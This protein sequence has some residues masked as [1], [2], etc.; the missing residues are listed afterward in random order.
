MITFEHMKTADILDFG[1]PHAVY[2]GQFYVP[3]DPE[4]A[5]NYT[6]EVLFVG[7]M[8]QV[9]SEYQRADSIYGLI[10]AFIQNNYNNARD[11]VIYEYVNYPNN[12]VLDNA[13]YGYK[14]RYV[15]DKNELGFLDKFELKP[16]TK[17][18]DILDF[19]E[20]MRVKVGEVYQHNN[21]Q[22]KSHNKLV[23]GVGTYRNIHTKYPNAQPNLQ[24]YNY[25][26][27][28]DDPVIVYRYFDTDTNDW[29]SVLSLISIELFLE[30]NTLL[31][32]ER[33]AAYPQ[34]TGEY[35]FDDFKMIATKGQ[36]WQ[37]ASTTIRIDKIITPK[38]LRPLS[39]FFKF[40]G[41]WT[42]IGPQAIKALLPSSKT[43]KFTTSTAP[44]TVSR[45][46]QP[47]LLLKT[48]V[49]EY[50]ITPKEENTAVI[51][52]NSQQTTFN[53]PIEMRLEQPENGDNKL[54]SMDSIPHEEKVANILEFGDILDFNTPQEGEYY[55]DKKH[56]LICKVI[57]VGRY[58]E[59]DPYKWFVYY[60]FTQFANSSSFIQRLDT[61]ITEFEK[62]YP[63]QDKTASILNFGDILDSFFPNVGEFYYHKETK[64]VCEVLAVGSKAHVEEVSGWK[65]SPEM[66]LIWYGFTSSDWYAGHVVPLS[67]FMEN[68]IKGTPPQKTAD[69]LEFD[70]PEPTP[71]I[72]R[73]Y[74][75][76]ANPLDVIK[77]VAFGKYNDLVKTFPRVK[78]LT[79]GTV[80][81]D[82]RRYFD[83]SSGI[84][85]FEERGKLGWTPLHSKTMTYSFDKYVPVQN[86]TSAMKFSDILEHMDF[87]SDGI[88]ATQKLINVLK[89]HVGRE[90]NTDIA[91][92]I[93]VYNYTIPDNAREHLS[94]QTIDDLFWDTAQWYLEDFIGNTKSDYSWI[95]EITQAGRSGGWLEITPNGE[96]LLYS[97]MEL[98]DHNRDATNAE[99]MWK[100][101]AEY[102]I[103]YTEGPDFDFNNPEFADIKR[104]LA[105]E[106]DILAT[107][108]EIIG[109]SVQQLVRGFEK[110]MSDPN[111]WQE[112]IDQHNTEASNRSS[113]MT[114]EAH[115]PELML[116]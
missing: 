97:F 68:F 79:T 82:A 13:L 3:T 32:N 52:D 19:D 26:F 16:Y 6:V 115:L 100:Y 31:P 110:D 27:K 106:I 80:L 25:D 86:T 24:E 35:T 74:C 84:V 37:T 36:V 69:I 64:N 114:K 94:E 85:I 116:E 46:Y 17:Q 102:R 103:E 20:P 29:S 60:T 42:G 23:V 11:V 65:N 38:F 99:L 5:N 55:K 78:C 40:K 56:G 10:Y 108:I 87:D 47:F 41:A 61:F 107:E 92:K 93:K 77:V 14:W 67:W 48:D 49:F 15:Q 12:D 89:G 62:T 59:D 1:P 75:H 104:D 73:L 54:I 22:V 76:K 51:E 8:K 70:A 21:I 112:H 105:K 9:P 30:E 91:F 95:K 90:S 81:A 43:G 63:P 39:K 98:A 4:Y 109:Q 33:R 72:G 53:E 57:G 58:R 2:V 101:I 45:R 7:K 113:N 83:V 71:V 18:A 88:K 44:W 50:E 66:D 96:S 34:H 28:N 111:W